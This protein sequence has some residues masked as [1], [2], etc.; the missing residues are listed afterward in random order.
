MSF[1]NPTPIQVGSWGTFNGARYRVAGRLVLGCDVDG[2][3]Y[4]WNEFYLVGESGD[5]A[6]L[7]HEVGDRG[8][9]W[10]MFVMFEPE[11]PLSAAEAADKRV[12]DQLNLEGT[13]ARI[14]LVDESRVYY[15]E[16]EAPEGVELGDA[17]NYFNARLG[18]D[19]VV[20]S[21]TGDEVEYYRGKDISGGLVA[22]AFGLRLQ[23]FNR[24]A[25]SASGSS[26]LFGASDFS[27]S[28][29]SGEAEIWSKRVLQVLVILV[30]VAVIFATK[31]SCRAYRRPPPVAKINA[32]PPPFAY[33]NEGNF[34]GKTWRIR[35]Q[36]VVEVAEVGR[37]FERHEYHLT[38]ADGNRALLVCGLNPGESEWMWFTPL[39]P[40]EPLT[41]AQAGG[42]RVGNTVNVDGWIGPVTGL[43]QAVNRQTSSEL[44]EVR[45]G[46]VRFGFVVPSGSTVLLVR[47]DAAHITFHRGVKRSPADVQKA[48][49]K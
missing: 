37:R 29:F 33:G 20:V 25:A 23:D 13:D 43:F 31:T 46:D 7:V 41:P 35:A 21:W 45:E 30:V 42:L 15:I 47:W 26:S 38:A 32:P 44:P 49:G 6:T 5:E 48:F 18:K 22:T 1:K 12:G 4:Y 14:T 10:R 3:R 9:E 28:S 39:E 40:L 27:S 2:E 17:A 19:M 34:E 36:A 24:S 8:I 16:G 11:Y